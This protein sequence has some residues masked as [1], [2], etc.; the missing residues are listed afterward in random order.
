[1]E[2]LCDCFLRPKSVYECSRV[3][4]CWHMSVSSVQACSSFGDINA[5]LQGISTICILISVY[6]IRIRQ[7]LSPL[8]YPSLFSCTYEC[9]NVP[10]CV[11]FSQLIPP[12]S[13]RVLVAYQALRNLSK[14]AAAACACISTTSVMRLVFAS[15]LL[16]LGAVMMSWFYLFRRFF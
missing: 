3:Y 9:C 2:G 4:V 16:V 1:M 14:A 15:A 8:S 6:Y 10:L 13:K 5:L 7:T 12:F 11:P